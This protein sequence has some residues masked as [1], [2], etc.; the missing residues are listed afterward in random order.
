M[1]LGAG[2]GVAARVWM[3]YISTEPEFSWTGT[4]LIVG[5][6]GLAGTSLAVVDVLRRRSARIWRVLLALPALLMFA[7]PGMLMLPPALLGGFALG[8][9]GPRWLRL[10]VGAVAAVAAL[11]PA[12][13]LD[14][15]D[16]GL[17]ALPGYLLLCAGL[18]AGWSLVVR[19]RPTA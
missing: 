18:A 14:L 3:R 8:R 13:A 1:V 7:S 12:I 4:L 6:A 19:P 11:W 10:V 16:D 2:W 9:R 15:Q 17:A 5:V